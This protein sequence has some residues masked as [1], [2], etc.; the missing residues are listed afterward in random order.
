MTE[1]CAQTQELTLQ[2][3]KSSRAMESQAGIF[4]IDPLQDPRW[5]VF[6][7]RRTDASIFHSPGWLQALKS[8]YGY[9]PCVLSSTPPCEP[10]T[11][12]FVFC[13][14]RSRL[15]GR[16]L[17]S[18]PFSDHCDPL[19]NDP[20]EFHQLL[21][22]LTGRAERERLKYLEIRPINFAPRLAAP[23][24]ISNRYFL[25][26][27]DL[28]HS[29]EMLFRSF[30][31]NCVQRTIRRAQSESLRY[32]EG[33]S[34]LLLNQFY[35]LLIMTRRRQGV[36][37]QPLK[38]FRSL[39]QC[40][41]SNLKIRVALKGDIPVASILTIADQKKM[42]YKYGCRDPRF[43]NLGGTFLLLWR[44]IQEAK[45]A[46]MKEFDLGRSDTSNLGL[47][48]FKEHWAAKR[49]ALN[50]WRYPAQATGFGP[51][52]AIK[53]VRRLLSVMPD[54]PLG[55]LGRLLYPHSG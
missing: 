11:N 53:Q 18:I 20:E 8:C 13:Q 31:K 39:I 16:R 1:I 12:G 26:R 19:V 23:F 35:K 51:E 29:E 15:T 21:G 22:A 14:V 44:T 50:Y 32:E 55:M 30:H 45:A 17:V 54:A 52:Y 37:P 10:L 7:D 49:V 27:L 2:Q 42:V 5:K 24:A 41:G 33:C 38:W 28:H 46:G 36:P 4:Q 43:N 3:N 25:H 6:V 34:E 47:V 48:T 40:I 9:E